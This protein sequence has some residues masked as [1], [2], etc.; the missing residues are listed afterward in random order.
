MPPVEIQILR[1]K[2]K[3]RRLSYSEISILLQKNY[4]CSVSSLK[5]RKGIE[6]DALPHELL[7]R[8]DAMMDDLPIKSGTGSN[9]IP[10]RYRANNENYIE[11]TDEMRERLDYLLSETKINIAQ[12]CR[13]KPNNVAALRV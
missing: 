3:E 5:I 13:N 10:R 7:V 12:L 8:I 11:I 6:N 2:I 1:N 4:N 9:N